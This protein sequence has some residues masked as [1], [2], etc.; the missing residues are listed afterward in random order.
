MEMPKADTET[1]RLF[2]SLVPPDPG[3]VVKKVFGHPAAF[4]HGNMFFGVFGSQIW[5]RLPEN[6]RT[7]LLKIQ[8]ARPFEPMPGRPM[9]EYVVLPETVLATPVVASRWVGRAL[10][11]GNSLPSKL[12]EG[13][14]KASRPPTSKA[15]RVA[16][17]KS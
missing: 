7:D 15:P 14:A 4:A 9:R 5:V 6:D 13:A 11:H 16:R 8:G 17:A 12:R 3:V 1:V 2:A 10:H